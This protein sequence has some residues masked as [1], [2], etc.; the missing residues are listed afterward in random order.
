MKLFLHVNKKS[1]IEENCIV[2]SVS[3]KIEIDF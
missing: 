2:S 3:K 1:K